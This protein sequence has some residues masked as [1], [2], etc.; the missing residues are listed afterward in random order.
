ME[1]EYIKEYVGV[2]LFHG[3][4]GK[5]EPQKIVIDG[6]ELTILKIVDYVRTTSQKVGG[7]GWRYTIVIEGSKSK[8][9]YLFHEIGEGGNWFV[10]KMMFYTESYE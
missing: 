9:R 10:E 2:Y 7:L 1:Q 6:R 8:Q 5:I 3:S 4:D